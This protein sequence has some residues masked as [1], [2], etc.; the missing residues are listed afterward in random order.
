MSGSIPT[1]GG[2]IGADWPIAGSDG[3]NGMAF[4]IER[5]IASKAFAAIVRVMSVSNAGGISPVGQ[6]SVQPMVDQIDG[7]GNRTAHGTIYNLPYFRMQGGSNAI[8]ID[9]V[10]GDLGLAVICDRDISS[11]KAN[12][13]QA[14]PGSWRQNDWA[15]GCYIG[16]FLN[17][18]PTQYIA[19]TPSGIVVSSTSPI[20]IQ[21]DLR[22]T[23]GITAGYGGADSVTLQHHTHGGS[24][25]PSAGT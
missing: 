12:K 6:V 2:Y 10:V 15:D 3:Y 25:P 4:V 18:T 8:I 11:V 13:G 21:G 22:V 23:G 1:A 14:A 9:P 19:F 17:G 24:V 5:L 16:G 20:L 7:L